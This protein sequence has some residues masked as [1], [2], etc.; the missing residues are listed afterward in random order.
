MARALRAGARVPTS[1]TGREEQMGRR[2]RVWSRLAFA[3][4]LGVA[5]LA[6][7]SSDRS[8]PRE[9]TK[10]TGKV[11]VALEA[12]AQSGRVYRLRDALFEVV[13]IRT[14]RTIEFLSS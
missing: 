3:A 4:A 11:T 6:A 2:N 10:N 8:D 1:G 7:C 5:Q 9:Q 14:G 12:T 13:E